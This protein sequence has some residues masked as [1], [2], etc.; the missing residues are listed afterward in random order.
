M[1]DVWDA[2]NI[3]WG[4]AEA[5]DTSIICLLARTVEWCLLDGELTKEEKN[6][7][8]YIRILLVFDQ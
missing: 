1:W 5:Y 4:T 7:N 3:L 8:N 2:L 6:P